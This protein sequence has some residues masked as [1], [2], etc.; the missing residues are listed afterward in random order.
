MKRKSYFISTTD[1][2]PRK[3]KKIISVVKKKDYSESRKY[4]FANFCIFI[5]LYSAL[6]VIRCAKISPV[7]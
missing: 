4:L 5:L 7:S 6:D 3:G 2:V 1:H